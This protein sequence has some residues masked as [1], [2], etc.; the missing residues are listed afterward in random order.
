V[1][2]RQEKETERRERTISHMGY[3]GFKMSMVYMCE[4]KA[5]KRDRMEKER[6]KTGHK[7]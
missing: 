5:E 1:R 3:S 6:E 7:G 4:A 2:E